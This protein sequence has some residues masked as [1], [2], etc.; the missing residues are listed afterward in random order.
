MLWSLQLVL[1][2]ED[3]NFTAKSIRVSADIPDIPD[4]ADSFRAACLNYEILVLYLQID[5]FFL[6]MRRLGGSSDPVCSQ[7][8]EVKDGKKNLLIFYLSGIHMGPAMLKS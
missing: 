5:R 4:I 7:T 8:T 6:Q 3:H 2:F 1:G